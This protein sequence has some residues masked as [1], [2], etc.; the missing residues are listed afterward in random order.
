MDLDGFSAFAQSKG[1]KVISNSAYGVY[2]G[3]PF[4]ANFQARAGGAIGVGLRVDGKGGAK[5]VRSVR[6]ALPKGCAFL[7]ANTDSYTLSCAARNGDLTEAFTA[8][9]DTVTGKMRETGLRAPEACPLCKQGGCDATAMLGGVY[10]PTHRACVEAHGSSAQARAEKELQGNY[11]TGFLGAVLG[12]AVGALPAIL[13]LNFT[14]YYVAY[15]YALIPLAAYF[16]YRLFKGKMDS[17]A[18]VCSILASLVNLFTVEFSNVFI[19]LGLVR[20]AIPTVGFAWRVFQ[21]YV[22]DR[23]FIASVLMEV[24]FLGLGVWF[25]WGQLRRT[26]H[27]DV[28]DAGLA[29]ATMMSGGADTAAGASRPGGDPWDERSR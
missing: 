14:N 10:V 9:M 25:A 18:M 7:A 2:N 6:K 20:G 17:G 22:Q 23:G 5:F 24:L 11:F 26:A 13:C 27:H 8:A 15:L 4:A 3:Y 29:A 19:Q 28:Q 1:W 21:D 12:G 16:G